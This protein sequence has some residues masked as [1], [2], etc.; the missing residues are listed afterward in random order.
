[1]VVLAEAGRAARGFLGNA[2]QQHGIAKRQLASRALER[3]DHVV[4]AQLRVVDDFARLYNRSARDVRFVEDLAPVL[5]RLPGERV[6]QDCP[7]LRRV[8]CLLFRITDARIG[9]Q[10]RPVNGSR[11]RLEFIRRD[12]L[13]SDAL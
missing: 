5:H 10:V 7:E 8:R 13:P 11:R 1:M 12:Q 3:N 4:R 2:V 6:I 9:R